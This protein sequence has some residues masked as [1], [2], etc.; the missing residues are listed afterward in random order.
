MIG[1]IL[2]NMQ[3]LKGKVLSWFIQSASCSYECLSKVCI[4]TML[5]THS[6]HYFGTQIHY[7]TARSPLISGDFNV[8]KVLQQYSMKEKKSEQKR[9]IKWKEIYQRPTLW[10]WHILDWS[11]LLDTKICVHKC[12]HYVKNQI[13]QDYNELLRA[14]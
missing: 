2:R 8:L 7:R 13:L 4:S 3:I 6:R 12:K 11:T 1:F 10:R 5:E 9:K 14:K